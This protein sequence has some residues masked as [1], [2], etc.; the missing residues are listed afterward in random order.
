MDLR[1]SDGH[2][3]TSK[4]LVSLV[5]SCISCISCIVSKKVERDWDRLIMIKISQ[6]MC[7]SQKWVSLFPIFVAA[8]HLFAG[9]HQLNRSRH[10]QLGSHLACLVFIWYGRFLVELW[11]S[12]FNHVTMWTE[13]ERLDC[14][15]ENGR[16]D[17][18]SHIGWI[19]AFFDLV[20]HLTK[21]GFFLFPSI[22]VGKLEILVFQ[23]AAFF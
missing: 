12:L 23:V 18:L 21:K 13:M 19:F 1:W 4:T 14:A 5:L 3:T 11:N 20:W 7:N 2:L 6:L 16:E 10:G 15:V 8:F 22:S 17:W 9:F